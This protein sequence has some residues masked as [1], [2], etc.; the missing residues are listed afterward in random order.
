M[1]NAKR[2]I[3]LLLAALMALALAGCGASKNDTAASAGAY[4]DAREDYLYDE[5]AEAEAPMPAAADE[6]SNGVGGANNSVPDNAPDMSEKI[7]YN[8]EVTLETTGFDDALERIAAMVRDMGGYMESTSVSG[9]NYGAISR[10]SAGARSAY[11]TIRIPSARFAEFTG[12]LTDLGNVPYS[13]TY[14]RNV[15]REYYDTQSRLDAYKVQET[16]L[17]EMLSVAETVED[18]LAIQRELTDVQYEIDSLT[19]TLRYYDNQVGYS[20]VDLTVR[21]VR[22]YTPEPT[23]TLTYWERMSKGFRESVHNTAEFFKELFLW[24]VT[25]LPWLIPLCAFIALLVALLRRRAARS[26]EIAA[27]RAARKA[28]RALRRA[29]RKARKNGENADKESEK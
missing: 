7:I 18:M 29:A 15:T 13:R 26:P 3:A 25:S 1:K 6:A 4:Y 22:E 8:A 28:A 20:T 19:G 10:G 5:P 23:I 12:S 24:F 17:L 2:I 21:E 16:R 11:Y 9:S 14:T 27:R